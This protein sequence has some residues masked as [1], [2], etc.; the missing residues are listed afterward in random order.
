MEKARQQLRPLVAAAIASGKINAQILPMGILPSVKEMMA[1]GG[2]EHLEAEMPDEWIELLNICGNPE[3][4]VQAIGRLVDA[5][6]DTVVLAPLPGEGWDE[7]R[8]FS[9]RLLPLLR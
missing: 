5:G 8:I 6:A 3:D 7:L 1:N 2:L 9:D 4:C